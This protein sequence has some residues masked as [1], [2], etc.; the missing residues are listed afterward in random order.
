[1]EQSSALT[2]FGGG[3]LLVNKGIA[4]SMLFL[5]DVSKNGWKVDYYLY[6]RGCGELCA[7]RRC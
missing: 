5:G 6:L 1:M 7:G 4:G 3:S 2:V